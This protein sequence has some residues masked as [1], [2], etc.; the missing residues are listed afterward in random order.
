MSSSLSISMLGAHRE[1]PETGDSELNALV[2]CPRLEN[3]SHR[4]L[5]PID[6]DVEVDERVEN[7]E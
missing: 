6:V 4:Q 5:T 1:M 3:E 2:R 7:E